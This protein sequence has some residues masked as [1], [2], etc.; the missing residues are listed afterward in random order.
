LNPAQSSGAGAGGALGRVDRL[1]ALV[2][3]FL[4]FVG[5]AV[6][7]AL[8]LF[9]CAEVF[10]RT[11][12]NKSIFGF[13]DVVQLSMAAFAFLGAAYCQRLG[14]HIRMDLAVGQLRGRLLWAAELVSTR[15]A[16]IVIALLIEGSWNHFLRAYQ[17][18]DTTIDAEV[19]TWPSKLLAPIGLSFLWLRLL[20]NFAGYLR[21][22][23]WP[24]AT[25]LAVPPPPGSH[26][27]SA[28][29]DAPQP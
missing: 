20:L 3:N 4:N 2:E 22:L 7:F 29:V 25:P 11:A 8:M 6:I 9:V 18:G 24:E 17:I 19:V 5:A 1:Y 21:L 13:I 27:V 23:R 28:E 16:I 26:H 12:L 10:C 15:V 14:G